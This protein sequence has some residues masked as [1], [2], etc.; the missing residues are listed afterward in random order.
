MLEAIKEIGDILIKRNLLDSVEVLLE[1][2]NPKGTYK[3][4]FCLTF[5]EK[6]G[7]FI[8][9]G[10]EKENYDSSKKTK[11]L[12]R[13]GPKNGPNF[14]PSTKVTEIDKTF[15]IKVLNWFK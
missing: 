11:Y 15:E 7:K 10:I 3:N 9:T 5:E 6:E 2:P 13:G 14:T 1:D 8:Y 4:V 12:F